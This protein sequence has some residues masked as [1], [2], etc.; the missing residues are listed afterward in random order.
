MQSETDTDDW[1]ARRWGRIFY[2]TILVATL[3]GIGLVMTGTGINARIPPVVYLFGFLGASV[4]AF[5]SFAKRFGQ[6]GRYRLK[7][8]SRTVAVFPLVTGV[9]LL[10][11]S[12]PDISGDLNVLAG[13]G[14]TGTDR[15]VGGL[16]FVAGIYVSTT[17]K[18]LDA[19][20]KRTLGYPGSH[21]E[22]EASEDTD[23][24]ANQ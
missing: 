14:M 6:A 16:V 17:L 19:F 24:E 20:A 7:I 1:Y 11:F 10:A 18:A 5:T 23:M 9:Y 8:I 3:L 12:F 22:R 21:A 15:L 4:Y 2:W 13:E